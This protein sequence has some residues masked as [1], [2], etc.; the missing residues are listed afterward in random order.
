MEPI[1]VGSFYILPGER[2]DFVLTANQTIDSY[3]IRIKGMADC[4][5]TSIY[6]T[7]I[8]KYENSPNPV[9]AAEVNY[10]NADPIDSNGIIFN[11]FNQEIDETN[12]KKFLVVD[13]VRSSELDSF[14]SSYTRKIAGNVNKK[15]FLALDMNVAKNPQVYDDVT[16][17]NINNE[18]E[19]WTSPQINNITFHM[20]YV[21]LIYQNNKLAND[22]FCNQD[23][24]EQGGCSK[25]ASAFC[26]CIHL[27][28][29]NLND[30][31]EVIVVDGGSQ[32]ENHPS[33][34]LYIMIRSVKT[35]FKNSIFLILKVHLH[36][37]SFA[38][39]GVEKV[40]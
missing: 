31:V 25:N 29:I 6:Q 36:G 16:W 33:N 3:W 13:Q 32:E 34:Y 37:Q 10:E 21:P 2:L 30:V 27:L 17:K 11:P 40:P 8:L 39:L 26:R 7:A 12:K 5:E 23:N 9:P 28:E 1:N 19:P 14:S 22:M 20:P 38:V 24:R 18:A 35:E 15:F 4:D